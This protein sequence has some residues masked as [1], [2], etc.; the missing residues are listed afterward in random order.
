[1]QKGAHR[2]QSARRIFF[3]RVS[4]TRVITREN[5]WFYILTVGLL[6]K[7]LGVSAGCGRS[8]KSF[9]IRSDKARLPLGGVPVLP[10]EVFLE[11]RLRLRILCKL[12]LLRLFAPAASGPTAPTQSASRLL[13]RSLF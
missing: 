3:A 8:K 7:Y 12:F 1:M 4:G 6:E 5:Q 11:K 2:I 10:L 13:L 9:R